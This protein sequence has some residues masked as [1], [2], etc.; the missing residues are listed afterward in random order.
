MNNADKNTEM[1]KELT[2]KECDD[3]EAG[4]MTFCRGM[5]MPKQLTYPKDGSGVGDLRYA[6]WE[7]FSPSVGKK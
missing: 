1:A 4:K 7:K 3:I 5:K 6:E 2:K